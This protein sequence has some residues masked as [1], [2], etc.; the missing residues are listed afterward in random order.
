[1]IGAAQLT[2]GAVLGG[3]LDQLFDG[4]I[5]PLAIGFVLAAAATVAAVTFGGRGREVVATPARPAV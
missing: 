5:L 2:I 3:V 4:T 1:M